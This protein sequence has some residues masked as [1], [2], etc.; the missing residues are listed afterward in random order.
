MPDRLDSLLAAIFRSSLNAI[1]LIDETGAVVE[2]NHTAETIF[3]YSRHEVLGRPIGDL[4]VPP[5]LRRAHAEGMQRYLATGTP[6]VLNRRV[7]IEAQR[8]D[9]TVFPVELSITE[10]WTDQGRHFAASLRD[11]SGQRRIEAERDDSKAR[12]EAF[13]EHAPIGMYLKDSSGRYIMANPEFTRVFGLPLD[14]IIGRTP[15]EL[16]SP[17]EAAMVRANDRRVLESG[18][19]HAE[20]EYLDGREAYAWTLVLRFPLWS[21][22]ANEWRVG[23]FDFDITP[24]KRAAEE[25]Q[26]SRDALHQSEKL[27]ALGS[28][29]AGVSHELNNPLAVVLAQAEMLA[30]QTE[31]TPLADRAA[32]IRRA[33]ERCARIVQ[34]FL[35][36][37][38]QKPPQ[39]GA[40]SLNATAEAVIDLL[41]YNLR[42][43]G[44]S[45]E[46][47][48]APTLPPTLGDQ[49]Q[50]HQV[51]LNLVTNA[52]QAMEALPADTPRR[53]VLTSGRAPDGRS[54]WL[55]VADTGP[56]IPAE[57]A[58][59]IF[60]P[61]FTTKPQGVGT[62]LGLSFSR[63]IVEG[64]GGRLDLVPGRGGARLRITLP[65]EEP[66]QD[67][68]PSPPSPAPPPARRRALIIDDEP[69]VAEALA[70]LLTF[71]GLD[72]EVAT[73]AATALARLD[74][75]RFDLLL[76]DIRMPGMS[77]EAFLAEL[78]AR[79][80]PHADRLAFVTGDM[81]GT[82]AEAFLAGTGRPFLAKPFDLAR[83]RQ[84]LRDMDLSGGT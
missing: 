52:V 76:T 40:F 17:D 74:G 42:T 67:G 15:E 18:R 83:L 57:V 32:R 81:L 23:G 62:G 72:T 68:D 1:I 36:M 47:R 6:H 59:R 33:A 41:A 5:H 22:A 3:G 50:L 21:E 19:P 25:V 75:R 27:N 38:R 30:M 64:H 9:G 44:V 61:F 10:V 56:G 46:R 45:V 16:L 43:H 70:E 11:L 12:L 51:L 66:A 48:L 28:L 39:R 4:I 60:D 84:L 73:D 53:L 80:D 31:G 34:T 65:L 2:F 26:R 82:R 49:D 79:G 58:G 37:A 24:L 69:D 8:A 71:L 63:A 13:M 35:A 20:E 14:Q 54:I 29:L 77:G 55:E 78:K 7:E